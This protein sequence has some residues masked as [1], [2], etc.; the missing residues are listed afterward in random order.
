MLMAGVDVGF[1]FTK[2]SDGESS[3]L[4]KSIIGEARP[5]TLDDEFFDGSARTGGTG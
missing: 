5:R 1:G 4:F 3:A 2:A